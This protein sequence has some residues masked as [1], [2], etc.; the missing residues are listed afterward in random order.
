MLS[1]CQC[2]TRQHEHF[3]FLSTD[4]FRQPRDNKA[5][6]F[7]AKLFLGSGTLITKGLDADV[8][9]EQPETVKYI[10]QNFLEKICMQR[11]KIEE[12]AFDRELKKVI[13]SHVDGPFRLGQSSLDGLIAFKAEEAN[14]KSDLLKQELHRIN[15]QIVAL[16]GKT[17][18]EHR[19]TVD[20]LLEKKTEELSAHDAIK[21]DVVP[22]P[23]V[24]PSG[25][26]QTSAV[27]DA[28]EKAK[29]ELLAQEGSIQKCRQRQAAI[30]Q[31]I[32]TADRVMARLD[33]LNRQIQAFIT[34]STDDVTKLGLSLEAVFEAKLDNAPLVAARQKLV[35]EQ[36]E[37]GL[38]LDPAYPGS[39]AEKAVGLQRTIATLSDRL[40]EP[41]RRYQAYEAAQKAWDEKRSAIVGN[42][43]TIGTV[44][45]YGAY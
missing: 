16:E 18:A 17:T 11:G 5:R 42:D 12:S 7:E 45:Y 23:D 28:I 9:D 2:N 15:E 22:K 27:S 25:E 8:D 6:H 32:A 34:E 1:D 31:L 3:T 29:S 33:N 38:S 19:K 41:N 44:W 40:D 10:P 4:N 21:L 14:K 39:V 37:L 13:F 30:A 20:N 35:S 24:D 36:L 43:E 26:S